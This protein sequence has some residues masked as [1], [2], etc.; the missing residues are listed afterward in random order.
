MDNLL[1]SILEV[2][3]KEFNKFFYTNP[4]FFFLEH[5]FDNTYILGGDSFSR[6]IPE[7]LTSDLRVDTIDNIRI[8]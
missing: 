6:T 1:Q 5:H 2:T 3:D 8:H 4:Y 7:S